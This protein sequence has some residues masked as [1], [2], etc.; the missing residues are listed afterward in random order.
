MNRPAA[1]SAAALG[2]VLPRLLL[3][4]LLL[5]PMQLLLLSPLHC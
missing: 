3:L 1:R 4:L 2:P 5:L